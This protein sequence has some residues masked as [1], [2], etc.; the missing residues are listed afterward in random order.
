MA[1]IKQELGDKI[2]KITHEDNITPKFDDKSG[3]GLNYLSH[4][5]NT[6]SVAEE[7]INIHKPLRVSTNNNSKSNLEGKHSASCKGSMDVGAVDEMKPHWN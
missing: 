7:N 4:L 2:V 3:R 5:G 1:S 6:L